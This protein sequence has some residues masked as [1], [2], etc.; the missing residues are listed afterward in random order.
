MISVA[1]PMTLKKT[2]ATVTNTPRSLL[3][4]GEGD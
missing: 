4:G 2:I 1:N 3:L